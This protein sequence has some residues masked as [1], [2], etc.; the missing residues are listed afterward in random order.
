MVTVTSSMN[1]W[2]CLVK[3]LKGH[4]AVW[5]G[6]R[7]LVHLVEGEAFVARF[8]DKIKRD[9]I[10]TFLDHEPVPTNNVRTISIYK[11]RKHDN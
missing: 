1:S 8:K 7:V 2:R 6:K 3:R 9:T 5:R 11:E 4:T 10:M